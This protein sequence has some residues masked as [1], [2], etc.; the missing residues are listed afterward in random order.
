MKKYSYSYKNGLIRIKTNTKKYV[1]V[2]LVS[3]VTAV[4]MAIPA[5]AAP[6]PGPVAGP[7]CFGKWRAGSVQVINGEAPGTVNAGVL[8]FSERAGD[9][10]TMNAG[11]RATCEAL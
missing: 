7:G 2:G 4:G 9:N 6:T 10:S 5:L 1:A 8:Y 3:L 11:A